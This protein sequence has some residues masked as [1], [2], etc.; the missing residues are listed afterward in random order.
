MRP[1][2]INPYKLGVELWRSIEERWNKGQ[3]GREYDECDD[4]ATRRNWDKQLGL[5]REKIFEVRRIYNDITFI[6]DFLTKE[7][8]I[9][10]KLFVYKYNGQ[11]NRY[12]I[13]DRD[14]EAIKRSL[15]FR[16]TNMG[17]PV[18]VIQDGNFRNRAELLLRHRH[19]GVDLE[20]SEARDTLQNMYRVWQRPVSLETSVEDQP[21][22]LSYDGDKFK[23]EDLSSAGA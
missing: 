12:E 7:F 19:E 8:C 6:D 11:T 23:E 18:I 1:G 16:L 13:A 10:H 22:L 2:T 20:V 15:L 4:L 3:F 14:F 5:G 17:H 21:R 9:Q